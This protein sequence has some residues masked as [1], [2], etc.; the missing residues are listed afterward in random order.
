MY[1]GWRVLASNS[2]QP[3]LKTSVPILLHFLLPPNWYPS[4]LSPSPSLWI[5]HEGFQLFSRRVEVREGAFD[6]DD[7][8][9][10]ELIEFRRVV[11]VFLFCIVHTTN[12]LFEIVPVA[13]IDH[14]YF[15]L[16]NAPEWV[17]LGAL[18]VWKLWIAPSD[19]HSSFQAYLPM[20]PASDSCKRHE[21]ARCLH[22][23]IRLAPEPSAPLEPEFDVAQVKTET[24]PVRGRSHVKKG[25]GKGKAR[26]LNSDGDGGRIQITREHRVSRIIPIDKPQSTWT[27]D[28]DT[29]YRVDLSAHKH[30]FTAGPGSK[31]KRSIQMI[32]KH[33]DLDAW[34]SSSG[35]HK[36]GDATVRGF[37]DDPSVLVRCKRIHHHCNGVHVCE[38][39]PESLFADCER[40]E[41]DE[42]PM[43]ELWHH[44]LDANQ[45]EATSVGRLLL[46]FYSRISNAKCPKEDC[47]GKSALVLLP[48]FPNQFGKSY[49]SEAELDDALEHIYIPI[50]VNLDEDEL[51]FVMQNDG[52][53]P[54]GMTIEHS[55]TCVFSCH[56]SQTM[57]FCWYGHADGGKAKAARIIPRPCDCEL[58]MFVPCDDENGN[59]PPE[60]TEYMALLIVRNF[61]NHPMHPPRKPTYAEKQKL[62]EVIGSIGVEGLTTQ[63]LINRT[64]R[65]SINFTH[66]PL[67]LGKASPGFADVRRVKDF[68]SAQMKLKYPEGKDLP[69]VF[70]YMAHENRNIHPS[71]RFIH[72]AIQRD[73]FSIVV[74]MHPGLGKY[75]HE[76]RMLCIDFTFKRVEGNVDEWRA[77]GFVDRY[78]ART[79]FVTIYCNSNTREAF[80]LLFIQ[81][82]EVVERVTG[83][84]L[85]L[86]PFRPDGNCRVIILDGEIPQAQ[87]FGD[88]LLGYNDPDISGIHS[89]DPLEL[90]LYSLKCCQV[91]FQ[92]NISDKLPNSD[93]INKPK[94]ASWTGLS[95]QEQFDD[96]HRYCGEH[97]DEAVQN[98]YQQKTGRNTFYL[99]TMNPVTS[100]ITSEDWRLTPN[101]TNLVE[102]EHAHLTAITDIRLPLLSSILTAQAYYN[103]KYD[104][105]EQIE[106]AAV[107]ANRRNGIGEREKAATSATRRMVSKMKKKVV[108]RANIADYQGLVD[109]HEQGQAQ[110]RAS[111]AREKNLK[112]SIQSL[113]KSRR[114]DAV[115]KVKELR[116]QIKVGVDERR[117]WVARR[118]EIKQDL[119]ILRKG[120]LRGVAIPSTVPGNGSCSRESAPSD[121]DEVQAGGPS[122]TSSMQH[123]DEYAG[124]FNDFQIDPTSAALVPTESGDYQ[125]PL[126]TAPPGQAQLNLNIPDFTSYGGKSRY[127]SNYLD[128]DMG[129]TEWN[130]HPNNLELAGLVNGTTDSDTAL[131][132]NFLAQLES[133]SAAAS[134]HPLP[135]QPAAWLPEQNT[136]SDVPSSLSHLPSSPSRLPSKSSAAPAAPR[137][138]AEPLSSSKK[139]TSSAAGLDPN[140]SRESTKRRTS[141]R[142]REARDAPPQTDPLTTCIITHK[143]SKNFFATLHP[144]E[145]KAEYPDEVKHM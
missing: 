75:I 116:A 77:A 139:R 71:K 85:Q 134:A 39:V 5:T 67:I 123:D 84:E 33:E 140:I 105:F 103:R 15:S 55:S 65:P 2:P 127:P 118:A 110:W 91:H 101:S 144:E 40:Y 100:K 107:I 145:F 94:L 102:T 32:L 125:T 4:L 111:L 137:P 14:T 138:P 9:Q 76:T 3:A 61:H 92:R 57:E 31:K 93:S 17:R 95:T 41:A 89:R 108:R 22:S 36:G 53:L 69:G 11:R 8:R 50:P 43:L 98:W 104:E 106:S 24:D 27:V 52:H 96:W 87:G 45:Q 133:L 73:D 99:K 29:A 19:S 124:E 25:K 121:S 47:P 63:R 59:P 42:A 13:L 143:K 46:R 126:L 80:K 26:D 20:L 117:I 86:R 54:E 119:A 120:D 66:M 64:S 12:L 23:P 72:A 135:E 62:A 141:R 18:V 7:L 10:S 82:F 83:R 122:F 130:I 136:V 70:Y 115:E 37:S 131:L 132:D 49:C 48:M 114:N 113:N 142:F 60:F 51:R 109:E 6:V 38:L 112:A 58:I 128:Y 129:L 16:D 34:K 35:G 81:L 79:T 78:N 30:L 74:T 28:D 97:S 44:M 1:K 21:L 56:P 68:I 88:F 90:V